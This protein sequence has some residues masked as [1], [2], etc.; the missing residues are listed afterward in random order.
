MFLR[1]R[2]LIVIGIVD[3]ESWR[4]SRSQ[5]NCFH[6]QKS[7]ITPDLKLK[8][9]EHAR[10]TVIQYTSKKRPHLAYRKM[11]GIAAQPR[12]KPRARHPQCP[13]RSLTCKDMTGL[14][15]AF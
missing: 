6:L 5:F 14:I 7:S 1:S 2:W 4:F 13:C 10:E 9:I 11:D 8:F 3:S 12:G 15:V